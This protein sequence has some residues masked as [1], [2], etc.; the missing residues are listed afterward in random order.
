M[1]PVGT[2]LFYIVS[3]VLQ[4]QPEKIPS[5]LKEK[6]VPTLAASYGLWPAAHAI[7]FKFVP[8]S[9]RILYTNI[10]SVCT[11]FDFALICFTLHNRVSLGCHL[12]LLLC[13]YL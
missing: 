6:L 3:S 9:Q 7:N 4:A 2:T 10:V 11:A 5:T 1:A 12:H 8:S 13:M